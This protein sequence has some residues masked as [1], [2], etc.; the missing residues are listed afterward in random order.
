MLSIFFWKYCIVFLICNLY[1]TLYVAENGKASGSS[2]VAEN[3][4]ANES[5]SLVVA[6]NGK[7][8][9]NGSSAVIG[10]DPARCGR[11]VK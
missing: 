2:A 5:G 4:K 6:E 11:F 9:K 3:S 8:N 1:C 7:A 10:W